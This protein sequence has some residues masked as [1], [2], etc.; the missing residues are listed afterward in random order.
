MQVI[1][2]M[3]LFAVVCLPAVSDAGTLSVRDAVKK[4]FGIHPK[5]QAARA[6]IQEAEGGW[7]T[8]LS[9]PSPS[10]SA[11]Y[12]GVP[13][14]SSPSQFAERRIAISQEFDF[15]LKYVWRASSATAGLNSSKQQ[16]LVLLLDLE[17]TIRAAYTDAWALGEKLRI[18]TDNVEV[19]RVY[20]SQLKRKVELGEAVPLEAR[21]ARVEY[22]QAQALIDAVKAE[23]VALR[24]RLC[25]LTGLDSTALR[26]DMPLGVGWTNETPDTSL[27]QSPDLKAANYELERTK[28]EL[29]LARAVWLPD[30]EFTYFQQ[31][32][33]AEPN[34]DFWGIEAGVSLPVWFWLGGRGEI[35]SAA[36]RKRASEAGLANLRIESFSE[37][38]RLIQA[39]NALSER[40]HLYETD[41]VPAATEAYD[42]AMRSFQL[43]EANYL[44]VLDAQ[45][46]A[47]ETRIE[48]I[49]VQ[50]EL[51]KSI[52]ELDRLVG[53]SVIGSAEL[54]S[55]LDKG[56]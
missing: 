15:P 25:R 41:V 2:V 56:N 6:A 32:A 17:S 44:Q 34:P 47:L 33:P 27:A 11:E 28:S 12:E 13:R 9:L 38:D 7:L 36:A 35:Q 46:S 19:A 3:L 20:A 53:R 23:Q 4:G 8:T 55:L 49:E 24:G 39:L 54:Q 31:K 52:A 18:L 16:A 26:L 45:R 30:L 21:R 51:Y 5:V 43:G 10:L 50:S 48:Y 29:A 1:V 14:S 42:L 40:Y 37:K 22:L